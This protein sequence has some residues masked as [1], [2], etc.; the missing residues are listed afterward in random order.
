MTITSPPRV[1]VYGVPLTRRQYLF[2]LGGALLLLAMLTPLWFY[3][4]RDQLEQVLTERAP[5]LAPFVAIV[6]WA[7]LGAV[8]LEAAEVFFVLRKFARVKR[9]SSN[10]QRGNPT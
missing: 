9:A 7:V 3:S 2:C 4:G 5:K 1:R 6:P 8:G 10:Q